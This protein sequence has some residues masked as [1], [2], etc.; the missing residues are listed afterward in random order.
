MPKVEF[1]FRGVCTACYHC[2]LD[3]TYSLQN[4]ILS[5]EKDTARAD[6]VDKTGYWVG[7]D[8]VQLWGLNIHNPVFAVS[9]IGTI[10][11]VLF[12]IVFSE[13]AATHFGNLRSWITI[14]FDWFYTISVDVILLVCFW[15]IISPMG[16]VRIGG[17]DAKPDY[18]YPSWFAMMFAAGVGIGLMFY[19][20]LEPV[21]HFLT[22]PLG[23]DPSNIEEARAYGVSAAI[24][25][26][27]LHAWGVYSL[28]GLSL[29]FFYYN[30]GLPLT[31]RSAFYPLLGEATWRWP[32][33]IID[34]LAVF[35]ILFGLATSLG[36]GAEQVTGG[37]NYL[38]DIPS[39]ITTSVIVVLVITA[40]ALVSVVRGLDKGVKVLSE[41]NVGLAVLFCL[42]AFLTGSIIDNFTGS[43]S[44]GIHYLV[45]LPE[46]SNWIGREDKPFLRDWSTF[47]W[48]WWVAWSPFVGMFIA[49]VSRGRTAREFVACALALPTVVSI[50]W[51][52][53]FGDA[54]ISQY[55]DRGYTGVTEI[56]ENWSP[57]L[58]M[59]KF[60][61]LLPFS[62]LTSLIAIFL[63][64]VFFVT[65][66][67]SGS[68]VVDTITAGG[69]IDAPIVQRIFWC[70][71][72][73]LIAIAL[74]MGGGLVSLQ[75]L[76]LAS[77]FPFTIVLLVMIF[78]LFRGLKS[79]L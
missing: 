26:W 3:L 19:G 7:R 67:D 57:E 60:L 32:G 20:V 48:S 22:P 62:A 54:A 61:E 44:N 53:V 14:H 70:C 27:S 28:V 30:K 52:T 72:E 25:H 33:H 68:L 21:N 50:I 10:A 13:A 46:F 43:I 40:V 59:F 65:S 1:S 66:M 16:K 49:R 41:I 15:I 31:I 76:S 2:T 23:I 74:L 39:S 71:F 34:I 79:E 45:S 64:I 9:A 56:V 35:A 77:G 75:A 4:V 42:F 29:A 69:M 55:L 6:S 47:Y 17:K 73:G 18:S 51:M 36:L 24:A 12:T 5:T 58:S 78:P 8:N 63:I 11:F 38:F 37:L